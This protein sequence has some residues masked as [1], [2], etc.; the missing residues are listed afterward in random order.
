MLDATLDYWV[1]TKFKKNLVTAIEKTKNWRDL[2]VTSDHTKLQT[3]A[4]AMDMDVVSNWS[5]QAHT[6]QYNQKK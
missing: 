1:Y 4:S 2:G 3:I 5:E 6:M